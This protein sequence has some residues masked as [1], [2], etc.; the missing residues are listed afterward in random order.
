VISDRGEEEDEDEEEFA[1]ALG[2]FEGKVTAFE[3]A[4]AFEGT[5]EGVEE[6][7]RARSGGEGTLVA[8][9][10]KERPR[11]RRRRARM[12][13]AVNNLPRPAG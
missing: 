5:S 9:M 10:K 3:R 1:I 8:G 13:T 6:K 2:G 7:K 11:Q 12:V 4:V